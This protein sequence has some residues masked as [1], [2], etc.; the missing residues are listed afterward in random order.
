MHP[1]AEYAHSRMN[2]ALRSILTGLLLALCTAAAGVA[3][4]AKA[5]AV[6]VVRAVDRI[7]V[8]ERRERVRDSILMRIDQRVTAICYS[9]VR[10]EDSDLC[11]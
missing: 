7:D 1:I 11:R 4:A 5:N 10:G 6:D 2:S 9:A 8:L 3:W